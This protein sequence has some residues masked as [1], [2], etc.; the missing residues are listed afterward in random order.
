MVGKKKGMH[1]TWIKIPS[2]AQDKEEKHVRHNVHIGLQA[3]VQVTYN[4]H[5]MLHDMWPSKKKKSIPSSLKLLLF[6]FG[7]LALIGHKV[8][9][10]Y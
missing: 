4:L 1:L 8:S 5:Y 3:S 9:I 7:Y 2:D 10:N 6:D